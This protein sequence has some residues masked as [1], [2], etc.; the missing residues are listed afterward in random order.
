MIT[1]TSEE[2]LHLSMRNKK[3]KEGF[4]MR[5]VVKKEDSIKSDIQFGVALM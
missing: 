4:T 5:I 1:S 2:I 3:K